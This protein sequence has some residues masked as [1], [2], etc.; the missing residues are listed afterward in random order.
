[1]KNAKKE[2]NSRKKEIKKTPAKRVRWIFLCLLC[3]LSLLPEL[4]IHR[5]P[6]FDIDAF[7]G[8]YALLGSLSCAG[9]ILVAKFCGLFLKRK[10]N[11][12]QED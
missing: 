11:Y 7:F 6:H 1:M 4:F 8:F 12:Y 2:Q 3:I 10:E 9:L 5:H